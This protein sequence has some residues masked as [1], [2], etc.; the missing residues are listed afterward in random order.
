MRCIDVRASVVLCKGV[1]MKVL[2]DNF[3]DLWIQVCFYAVSVAVFALFVYRASDVFAVHDAKPA[4]IQA[5]V[6][7]ESLPAG[8]KPKIVTMG[9]FIRNFVTFDIIHNTIVVDGVVSAVFD[10]SQISVDEV[11]KFTIESGD[12]TRKA[13]PV[14]NTKGDKTYALWDVRLTINP[15]FNFTGYPLDSHRLDIVISNYEVPSAVVE[16]AVENKFFTMDP[17]VNV[18]GWNFVG[19]SVQTGYAFELLPFGNDDKGIYSPRVIFSI[20]CKRHDINHLL[21]ILLPMLGLFFLS[22]LVFSYSVQDFM[23]SYVTLAMAMLA[24]R[25]VI[26]TM[27]PDTSYFMLSDYL[28]LLFLGVSLLTFFMNILVEYR[29]IRIKVVTLGLFHIVL[30]GAVCY[31]FYMLM[32]KI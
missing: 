25:F 15:N 27:A 31:V 4:C 6:A 13:D 10:K 5:Q 12:V 30:F 14:V 32:G 23:D 18:A 16:F 19:K 22:L 28:F 3:V 26:Q 7:Q 11:G 8:T 9:L 2:R 24:Y 1:G 20:D 17:H 21:S 29:S